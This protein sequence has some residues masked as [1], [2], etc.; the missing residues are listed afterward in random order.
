MRRTSVA[1]LFAI[2]ACSN[3]NAA[4]LHIHVQDGTGEALKD[5]LVI[6]QPLEKYGEIFRELTD[7]GGNIAPR[8]VSPGFYRLIVTNP[9]GLWQTKI[10]EFAINAAPV[11]IKL[12][13]APMGTHGYGDR[14]PIRSANEHP[15]MLTVQF[16]DGEGNA[17]PSVRFLVRNEDL[18]FAT[19][20]QSDNK[21]IKR[22][23]LPSEPITLVALWNGNLATKT[24]DNKFVDQ[25]D[26]K[27]L[28]IS[29][30]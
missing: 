17:A 24:F 29:L 19:W 27:S 22:V 18:D 16:V 20:Y 6:V 30:K 8:D 10:S 14:V 9:Y 13:V 3:A 1:F 26:R 5:Q 11:E 15:R 21:G 28:V 4:S 23:E 7:E 25:L 2:L 12:T